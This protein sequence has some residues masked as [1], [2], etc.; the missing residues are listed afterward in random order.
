MKETTSKVKRQASEWEKIIANE[1]TDKELISK[2]YKQF[3]KLNIRKINNPIKK[4]AKDLNRHFSKEDIQMA[5]KH[6]NRWSTSLII[7]RE[8]Q[9]KP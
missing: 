2:I 9:S 5:N 8:M 7:I 4:W 3:M 1:A 6:M